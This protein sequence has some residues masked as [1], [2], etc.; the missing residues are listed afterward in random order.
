[1]SHVELKHLV[2]SFV[3]CSIERTITKANEVKKLGAN[4]ECSYR[5]GVG[6][7][8]GSSSGTIAD[9]SILGLTDGIRV[10]GLDNVKENV[11]HERGVN[12]GGA[13]SNGHCGQFVSTFEE[14]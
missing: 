12:R 13:N 1:M 3:P 7:N 14:Y 11:Q 8:T 9:D 10:R 6:G 5:S 2:A 4:A